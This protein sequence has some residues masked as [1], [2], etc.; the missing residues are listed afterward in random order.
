MP[1]LLH[2]KTFVI[3]GTA[4][5]DSDIRGWFNRFKQPRVLAATVVNNPAV[6]PTHL[7]YSAITYVVAEEGR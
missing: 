1:L 4:V 3:V 7:N 5:P 2:V 6:N